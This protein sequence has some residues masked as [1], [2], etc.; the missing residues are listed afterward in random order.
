MTSPARALLVESSG[1]VPE[2]VAAVEAALRQQDLEVRRLDAGRV[3]PARGAMRVVQALRGDAAR[4][5]RELESWLPDVVVACEPGATAALVHVT[6]DGMQKVT[7]QVT[8]LGK[9]VLSV[10][11]YKVNR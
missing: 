1:A 10:V 7:V 5:E 9:A 6:D 11:T 2:V 3:A 8:H 4:L